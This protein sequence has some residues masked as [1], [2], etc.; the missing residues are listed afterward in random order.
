VT[1]WHK[2]IAG[3][4]CAA[5]VVLLAPLG[6]TGAGA[7]QAAAAFQQ[8]R[9]AGVWLYRRFSY[10]HCFLETMARYKIYSP[11]GYGKSW[12]THNKNRDLE[13]LGGTAHAAHRLLR[14]WT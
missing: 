6:A 14:Q 12:P 1:A 5:L 9:R 8:V 7:Q 11:P 13:T 3:L 10:H 2:S 4:W